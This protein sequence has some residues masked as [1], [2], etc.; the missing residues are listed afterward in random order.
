[1][2][3]SYEKIMLSAYEV[4]PTNLSSQDRKFMSRLWRLVNV[5]LSSGTSNVDENMRGT[6]MATMNMGTFSSSPVSES[7][8]DIFIQPV[9]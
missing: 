5:A 1:M 3:Q 7:L 9:Q 2:Q 8:M 6:P 4:T